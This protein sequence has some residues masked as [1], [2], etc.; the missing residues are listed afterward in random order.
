MCISDVELK[1]KTFHRTR[2]FEKYSYI[3]VLLIDGG[4]VKSSEK[5]NWPQC[6]NEQIQRPGTTF[7]NLSDKVVVPRGHESCRVPS[8]HSVVRV[9]RESIA[10]WSNF[11]LEVRLEFGRNYET[12]CLKKKGG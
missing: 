9:P 6:E 10:G 5:N 12:S 3:R 7:S 11:G 8:P 4:A 2:F 1:K